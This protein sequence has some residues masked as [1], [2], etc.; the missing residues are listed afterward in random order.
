MIQTAT[1]R[2]QGP[3]GDPIDQIEQRLSRANELYAQQQVTQA[4]AL[5]QEIL[6]EQPTHPDALQA[7]VVISIQAGRPLEAKDLLSRLLQAYPE[8]PLYHDRLATLL[9]SLGEQ[10]EALDV[11][12]RLLEG[13]PELN[14]SRYN[15]ARLLR[16]AG[17]LE[18]ALEEYFECLKRGIRQPEELYTNIG[19][20]LGELNRPEPAAKALE[21]ALQ[22]NA[23]YVP[24]LY[25]QALLQ[26]E[27]GNWGQASNTLYRIIDLHPDHAD[28]M[29]RLA[30]GETHSDP[31]NP[32]VRKI[33]RALKRE[34]A[35][36][37]AEENLLY[38][39]GKIH[40]D[41]QRYDD[42]F[43]YFQQANQLSHRRAGPY[44]AAAQTAEVDAL[45]QTC[46]GEWLA[47]ITPVSEQPLIFICGM[48]RSGSTLLEQ[49]LAAHPALEAG[50]EIAYFPQAVAGLEGDYPASLLAGQEQL[51]LLGE[52]YLALL[53]KLFPGAEQVTNKRPD[54]FIY[55]GLIKALF[56]NARILNTVRDP[57]DTGLS[58]YCQNFIAGMP[59]A[60]QLQDIGHYYGQYQRLM[61][62]WRELLGDSLLDV[63]YQQLVTEPQQQLTAALEFL[64]L[65]WHEDCLRFQEASNRVRTASVTQV[66][67]ELHQDSVGRWR[68]YET[69]LQPLRDVIGG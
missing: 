39:L 11:Y 45:L 23:E 5:F 2:P 36:P 47:S 25:N 10:A 51:T 3:S 35:D 24:A 55:L 68:N 29:A 59:Y 28:A 12:R 56:P 41:C 16:R 62:H 18:K 63:E 30:H 31:V 44:D 6:N 33:K 65:D 66:R 43:Q 14:D 27:L 7:L 58:V 40:D 53:K 15:Y 34:S 20:I 64:G 4:E 46:S 48:F 50:G 22:L 32:L 26:E 54:N 57:L 1:S 69:E 21:Q 37:M 8:E 67:R 52:G 42:A 38:A 9:E 49:M 19:V 13:K 60:N 61:E 17:Q